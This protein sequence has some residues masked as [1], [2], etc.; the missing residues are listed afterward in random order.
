[1]H[2][3]ILLFYEYILFKV[4]AENDVDITT[5]PHQIMLSRVL[6]LEMHAD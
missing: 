5:A 4:F 6:M 3:E 1:M 2:P